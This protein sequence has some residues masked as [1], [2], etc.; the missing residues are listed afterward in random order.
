MRRA[1][2]LTLALL[3]PAAPAQ[4]QEW[5]PPGAQCGE[6]APSL[7]E[8]GPFAATPHV[9]YALV[10]GTRP[11]ATVVYNPGGPGVSAIQYAPVLT[12]LLGPQFNLLLFDPR[13]VGASG[14]LDCRMPDDVLLRPPVDQLRATGACGAY[15]GTAAASLST[16][17]AADDLEAIRQRI[18]IDKLE[19]WGAS[20]GAALMTAYARRHP[21][22]V[23]AMLLSG[24]VTAD[25]DP[26]SRDRARAF[27]RAIR[28]VCERSGGCA[29]QAVLQDL[30]TLASRLSRHALSFMVTRG[31]RR[32]PQRLD[33]SVLAHLVMQAPYDPR[34]YGRLPALLHAAAGGDTAPL[35]RD[36]DREYQ[37][38]LRAGSARDSIRARTAILCGEAAVPYDPAAPTSARIARLN[39]ALAAASPIGP[40]AAG[41]WIEGLGMPAFNCLAWPRRSAPRGNPG[42]LPDVPALVVS[43]D[44]DAAAPSSSARAVAREIPHAQFI[45]VANAGHTPEAERTGCVSRAYREFLNL[46]GIVDFACLHRLPPVRVP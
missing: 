9:G 14:P 43:G 11:V 26:L 35:V 31:G 29:G 3:A 41:S 17:A 25:A 36:A 42:P 44:L 30:R 20:Y 40:F 24:P 28:L 16:D 45:E 39:R 18:G 21:A 4:A 32:Y 27:A 12:R 6:L 46:P 23:G 2:I 15:L 10:R 1:L 34:R 13:G 5:C 37:T 7:V 38:S 33:E 8:A 22:H 19:L